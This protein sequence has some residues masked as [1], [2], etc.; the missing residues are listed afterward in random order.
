MSKPGGKA[1]EPRALKSVTDSLSTAL[2]EKNKATM[3]GDSIFKLQYIK[4]WKKY[5]LMWK[6][7]CVVTFVFPNVNVYSFIL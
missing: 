4:H 2:H 1:T 3:R 6:Q 5:L 7:E